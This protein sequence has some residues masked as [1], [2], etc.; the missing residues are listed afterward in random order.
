MTAA[1]LGADHV[2]IGRPLLEDLAFS[3]QL[4]K[5][6]KGLWKVPISEQAKVPGVLW[7]TW[8]PPI[9]KE[10]S[11]RITKLLAAIDDSQI[12]SL[13]E[14]YLADGVLDKYNE[15]DGM[16]RSKLEEGLKRFAH[17]ENETR[18]FI[19]EIQARI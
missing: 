18:K 16:T 13:D 5:Y 4:P 1:A 17:W 3:Y 19:E 11:Q 15:T 2:T 9:P 7:E 12:H 6:Q 10:T 8:N 14:D